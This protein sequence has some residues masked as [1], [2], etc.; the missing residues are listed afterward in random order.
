MKK[1][2]STLGFTLIEL[3]VT[4][5]LMGLVAMGMLGAMEGQKAVYI[6][7]ERTLETQEDAR[8]VLD[9]VAFD[10]RMAGFMVPPVVALSSTDG[11]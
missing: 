2:T 4:V 8:L 7:N 5:A 6:S 9:L 11:G 1:R 3:M 10:A